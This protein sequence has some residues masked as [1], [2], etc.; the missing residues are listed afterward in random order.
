MFRKIRDP[1]LI[2]RESI[3][4]SWDIHVMSLDIDY[5]IPKKKEIR[6]RDVVFLED[7]TIEDKKDCDNPQS[8]PNGLIDLIQFLL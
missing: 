8:S 3:A 4:T 7:Q 2:A 5:E 6:S 1:S